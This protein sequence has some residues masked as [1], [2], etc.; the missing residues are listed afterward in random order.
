MHRL[1]V[2]WP[3]VLQGNDSCY[4]EGSAELEGDETSGEV[5]LANFGSSKAPNQGC[6][7]DLVSSCLFKIGS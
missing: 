6:S 2:L 7:S 5:P 4:W 3:F 1:F